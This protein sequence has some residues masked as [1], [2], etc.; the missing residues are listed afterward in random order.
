[1]LV[2][3]RGDNLGRHLRLTAIFVSDPPYVAEQLPWREPTVYSFMV[4]GDYASA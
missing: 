1:V 2:L 3:R 4:S